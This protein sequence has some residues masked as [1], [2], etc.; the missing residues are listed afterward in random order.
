MRDWCVAS[1]L[2][3][4]PRPGHGECCRGESL[5]KELLRTTDPVRLSWLMALLAEQEIEAIVFDTHTS[6]LEGSIGAIPRRLL[7]GND[8]YETARRLLA[9][10][11][12]METDGS[13]PDT[14]LGGRVALRQPADQVVVADRCALARR[15][16][17]LRGDDKNLHSPFSGVV[18]AVGCAAARR[19][20]ATLR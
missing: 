4:W 1:I 17:E 16:G 20:S 18:V 11:G 3:G 13:R 12:E 8:D 10:A 6:I 15:V 14:L 7:V 5:V 9:D 19:G 2:L